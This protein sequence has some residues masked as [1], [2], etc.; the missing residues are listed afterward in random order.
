MAAHYWPR[1]LD[2]RRFPVE[3]RLYR[4]EPEVQV[5]VHSQRPPG[6]PLGQVVLV[7]GLE[8]SSQSG[9][10]KS[11]AQAVLAAGFA[12]H[13][14]NMR[15][16]GGTEALCPTTYH[17]GLTSDVLFVLRQLAR[18]GPAPVF[19]VGYS[20]GGNVALKL[21]GEL[22]EE[23]PALLAGICAVSTPIDLAGCARCLEAPVN[24]IYEQR[25]LRKLK[26]RIR[27][28]HR[29][30]PE[31]YPLD[32]LDGLKSIR[33]FDERFTAP[34]FGFRNAAHYYETQ[35]ASRFLSRIRIPVLLLQARDD[36]VIPFEVFE[37]PALRENPHL[38]LLA[39]EH[40]GHLG[41]L[42]RRRPRFW[43]DWVIIEWIRERHGTKRRPIPSL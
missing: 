10:M 9:Y 4:T 37:E 21:A 3:A 2:E 19:L 1:G 34:G 41:F 20:L 28:K 32:G 24:R 13:R 33:E 26:R 7:H 15:S 31:R 25:F 11:M 16:C 29:Y 40:G 36:P 38:E 22:G 43:A 39:V 17:S 14:V 12:A 30:L 23:A 8:G 35:S 27:V 5:L 6:T 42:S 18:Q